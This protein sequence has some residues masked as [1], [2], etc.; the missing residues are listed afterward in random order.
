[1]EGSARARRDRAAANFEPMTTARTTD[2]DSKDLAARLRDLLT[3]I[4]NAAT[5]PRF[6][7]LAQRQHELCAEIEAILRARSEARV[8][9]QHA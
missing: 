7:P 6:D 5:A 3:Q 4:E 2:L 1:M 8:P 9:R